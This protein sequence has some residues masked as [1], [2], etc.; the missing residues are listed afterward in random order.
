MMQMM[1]VISALNDLDHD[2]ICRRS[3][4]AVKFFHGGCWQ[5]ITLNTINT[6]YGGF[7]VDYLLRTPLTNARFLVTKYLVVRHHRQTTG[8]GALKCYRL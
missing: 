3:A 4:T 2:V 8:R 1:G 5:A 7:S 6:Y